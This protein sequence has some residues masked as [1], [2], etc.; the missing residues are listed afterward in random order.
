M[1]VII[2]MLGANKMVVMHVAH[3]SLKSAH[4]TMG[5]RGTLE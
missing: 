2:K 1:A 3:L 4:N 5:T